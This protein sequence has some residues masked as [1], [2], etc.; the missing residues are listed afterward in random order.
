MSIKRVLIIQARMGSTRLPGKVLMDLAGRPMLAQQIRRLKQCTKVD[1]I[2]VAT[3]TNTIDEPVVH[4]SQQE[5]VEVFRGSED[6]VLARFAGAARMSQAGVVVRVTADCPL[7]DPEVTDRVISELVEH[8]HDCDYAS[9]VLQRTYPH[10]LDVEAFFMETLLRVD[11]MARS[12]LAREHVTL[13]VYSERPELFLCR[14]VM[15]CNDNSDLCWT[16]DTA[17]DIRLV[18][19]V[20]EALG[21]G[22]RSR[23]YQEIVSFVRAHPELMRINA[24][25]KTWQ[26]PRKTP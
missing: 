13:F 20:Y 21:L 6:D 23:N 19:A 10:G 3:T 9:N 2:V 17:E 7:I 5:G 1:R 12:K 22:T 24:G 14:S 15:D 16:V 8:S 11:R 18:R 4:L 26:P 25:V